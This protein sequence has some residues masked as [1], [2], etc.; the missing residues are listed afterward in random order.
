MFVRPTHIMQCLSNPDPMIVF[1]ECNVFLTYT[2]DA[3]FVEHTGTHKM[4]C[5]YNKAALFVHV[6]NN[7]E[8]NVCLYNPEPMTV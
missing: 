7:T 5:L 2:Q 4:H 8:C 3:M 1:P 6:N